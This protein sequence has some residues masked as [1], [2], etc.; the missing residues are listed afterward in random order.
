MQNEGSG[1]FFRLLK[2]LFRQFD[3]ESKIDIYLYKIPDPDIMG[4]NTGNA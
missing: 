3:Y 2:L 4:F 1:V